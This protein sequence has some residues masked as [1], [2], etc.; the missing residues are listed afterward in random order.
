[1]PNRIINE[2]ILTSDSLSQLS[3][4]E[5]C[6]FFRLLVLV[7]DYGCYDARPAVIRGQAFSLNSVTDKQIQDALSHLATVGIVDLYTVGGKP[8]LQL[9][10]WAKYQR[11]RN[12]RHKYPT[13]EESEKSGG[14]RQ[15]A[16]SRGELPQSAASRGL[17]PIQ[18]ES[19]PNPRENKRPRGFIPPTVEEVAAYCKERGNSVDPNRFVDFYASKGWLVGR[20]QMKD[21]KAAVRN[22]EREERPAVGSNSPAAKP[23]PVTFHTESSIDMD[24]V[25]KFELSDVPVYGEETR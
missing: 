15:V 6:V 23:G 14:S 1:M 2:G 9:K 8:Y 12:S 18:S 4:F 17:N 20:A 3:W 16:A 19:N 22:W 13:F 21:W 10:T 24:K 7:D 5:N 11:I 25:R